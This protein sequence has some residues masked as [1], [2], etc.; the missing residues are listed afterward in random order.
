M[1]KRL[2]VPGEVT[3]RGGLILPGGQQQETKVG[4]CNI[5]GARFHRGGEEAW[6]RHVGRC[7]RAHLD[8]IRAASPSEK[9]KGTPFDPEM[10]NPDVEAYLKKVGERMIAEGRLEMR[11]NERVHNE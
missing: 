1:S 3:S 5:C 2:I 10:W 4:V 11:P 7:A 8:E 6:Q 9:R